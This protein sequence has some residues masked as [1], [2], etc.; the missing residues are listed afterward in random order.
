V[1]TNAL[2]NLAERLDRKEQKT[3]PRL[4]WDFGSCP[5]YEVDECHAYE[6]ARNVPRIREDVARLQKGIPKSFDKLF[7][8][9]RDAVFASHRRSALFWFYPEFPE[10]PY[11]EI[12]VEERRRR[13]SVAWPAKQQAAHAAALSP[14]ILP[15]FL[16]RDLRAGLRKHGR[17]SVAYGA[18]ELALIEIHWDYSNTSLLDAFEAWLSENRPANVEVSESKGAGNFIR[19]RRYDLKLLGAWRLLKA[20]AMPWD[21]AFIQTAFIETSTQPGPNG[22]GCPARRTKF[23]LKRFG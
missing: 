2:E 13:M 18:I 17:P 16:G 7:A 6:F 8:A 10:K 11:L 9:R 1:K 4:R 14:K 20:N 3:I 21:D 12:P 22:A 23:R 5:N 19:R 15:Q